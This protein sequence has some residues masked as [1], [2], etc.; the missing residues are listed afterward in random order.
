MTIVKIRDLRT[1][2][3]CPDARKWCAAQG[4]DWRDF[5]ANGIDVEIL[6]AT[7]DN[8]STIDRLEQAAIRRV[9]NGKL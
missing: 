1:V 5:L 6:R 8:L 9:E 4:I 3:I 7:R 2:G